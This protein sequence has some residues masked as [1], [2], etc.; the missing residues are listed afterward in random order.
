MLTKDQERKM[1]AVRAHPTRDFGALMH[2]DGGVGVSPSVRAKA[3]A[4][5]RCPTTPLQREKV[6]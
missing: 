1:E 2:K 6:G 4:P 5:S 3:P